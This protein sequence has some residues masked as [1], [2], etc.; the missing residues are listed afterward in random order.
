MDVDAEDDENSAFMILERLESKAYKVKQII[1]KLKNELLTCGRPCDKVLGFVGSG[2]E[3]IDKAI[4]KFINAPKIRP[5]KISS[6][7][8]F[9]INPPSSYKF[10]SRVDVD[11]IIAEQ[12][13]LAN[14][15]LSQTE[16]DKL[17][18]VL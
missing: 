9:A 4:T 13:N 15:N 18:R 10:P 6:Q 3:C 17:G 16:M 12:N 8:S 11:Q 14:L 5:K 2:H 7:F 1:N